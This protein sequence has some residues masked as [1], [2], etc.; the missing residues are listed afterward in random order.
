MRC[1]KL[2]VSLFADL[3]GLGGVP[4]GVGGDCMMR[5]LV[6]LIK[7]FQV[8]VVVFVTCNYFLTLYAR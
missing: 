4:A 3:M 8:V 1:W 5:V 7:A 2:P 6:V